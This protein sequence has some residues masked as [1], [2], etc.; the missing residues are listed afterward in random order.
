LARLSP[1]PVAGMSNPNLI[2]LMLSQLPP[3]HCGQVWLVGAGPGDPGLLTMY[4]LAGLTQADVV[5]HDAL[6]S[7]PILDLAAPNARRVFAGK[8]GGRA[9]VDQADIIESL[10]GFAHQGLRVLRLKGG[11]PY[12]FGRGGEEAIALAEHRVPF[13]VIPGI[14]A[15]LGAMAAAFIP[16]TLRGVNQ[17]ILF[18]TGHCVGD[19][20]NC[21]LDWAAVA[22]LG[23]PIVLYMAV[24]R[25]AGIQRAL[26]AGGMSPDMPAAV[27][28][29]ATMRG[30]KVVV[31]TLQELNGNRLASFLTPPAIVIIGRIV[32][33]RSRL[34][35][36]LPLVNEEVRLCP[37]RA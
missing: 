18:A 3:L 12:M 30:Q 5:V 23:Q 32:A 15:G 11:D 36:L 27:V 37:L 8:R 17:A 1:I 10:I 9:S 14:T 28:H 13:R 21:G 7:A 34:M 26:I 16:A 29:S 20:T 22:K 2:Q 31:T 25:L 33:M 24:T 4:A 6:V 35:A 19:R